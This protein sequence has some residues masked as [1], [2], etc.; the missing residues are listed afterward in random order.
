MGNYIIIL[1]TTFV[2]LVNKALS[3]TFFITVK[4]FAW[5]SEQ[6]CRSVSLSVCLCVCVSVCLSVCLS[7][8][9]SIS[10][11]DITNIIANVLYFFIAQKR[12][13]RWDQSSSDDTPKK[14]SAWDA[15]VSVK[16]ECMV[17]VCVIISNLEFVPQFGYCRV[18]NNEH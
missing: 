10:W 11:Q 2:Q 15:E 3:I 4:P 14:K 9:V 18:T 12:A 17:R 5:R 8:I 6:I 1:A 7:L 13:R 16:C